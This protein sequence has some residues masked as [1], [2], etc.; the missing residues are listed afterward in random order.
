MVVKV[1]VDIKADAAQKCPIDGEY[2][3]ASELLGQSEIE[4]NSEMSSLG[5][6]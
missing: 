5:E 3:V 6:F 4:W 1:S 2:V